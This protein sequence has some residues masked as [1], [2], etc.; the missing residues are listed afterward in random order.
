VTQKKITNAPETVGE[1][2]TTN[3][4][5]EMELF[6]LGCKLTMARYS[7][8]IRLHRALASL[9]QVDL[10]QILDLST[11]AG[12][13][14]IEQRAVEEIAVGAHYPLYCAVSMLRQSLREHKIDLIE[15]RDHR[16]DAIAVSLREIDVIWE[17]LVA[18]P[19]LS[20][21]LLTCDAEETE[22]LVDSEVPSSPPRPTVLTI[23]RTGWSQISE[24]PISSPELCS[25]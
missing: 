24:V 4:Q 13:I 7:H 5:K 16:S 22:A 12:Q 25:A 9:D 19:G 17:T 3:G 6:A 8:E 11:Y 15:Y 14:M 2:Q 18:D 1:T 21:H 20:L 23:L 10:T